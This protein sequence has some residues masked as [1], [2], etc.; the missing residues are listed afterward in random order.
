MDLGELSQLQYLQALA[1]RLETA[2]HGQRGALLASA[3]ADLGVSRQTLYSRLRGVGWRSGRAL[4]ADAGD[5]RVS[6]AEV[7]EL[8]ALLGHRRSNGKRLMI[9]GDA[10]EIA[11]ANGLLSERISPSTALR[12]MRRYNCHPEQIDR[13]TPHQDLRSLHPN[14]VWQVDPSICVLFY[15]PG[16]KSLAVMDER[17]FNARKPV[18]L[19]RVLKERVIRYPVTDH[20]TGSI[21]LRY[22]LAPGENQMSLFEVLHECMSQAED[23]VMHGVPWQLI[24]DAGSANQSH[25][26]QNLW[27]GLATR[28]W[29]HL[30]QNPRGKGQVESTNNLVERRFESRLAFMQIHDLDQL[31]AAADAW[32]RDFNATQIHTRHGY[33]RSALWQTIRPEQLRLCPPRDVCAQLMHSKPEPRKVAGNLTIS[34]KPRGHE[35]GD[36][37]VAHIDDVRVGDQLDVIVNPYKAP[38]I[39]VITRDEHNTERYVECT[40][41]ERDGAG[42]FVTAP[43][44]GERYARPAD[45]PVEKSRADIS[46]KLW[47]STDRDAADKARKENRPAMNGRVDPMADIAARAGELPQH[48]RRRGTQLHLPNKVHVEERPVSVV[49]ALFDLRD[50]LG[51][52]LSAEESGAVRHWFPEGVPP[53]ALPT[54]VA[55]IEQLSQAGQ[56]PAVDHT[57]PPR[58]VAV[59]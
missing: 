9:V 1:A 45:T 38:A 25:G 3:A 15:M 51:R 21:F 18:A 44:I 8:A 26:I 2:G 56:A 39:Y 49:D 19:S 58:L 53:E 20:Y 29:T 37:S 59:R 22:V 7:R 12:L 5:S 30:P 4:R 40:P 52:P 24:W 17:Q 33:T 10:I 50:R 14:H 32:C 23:R 34:F 48:I 42:F 54:L 47:G 27:R 46:Q 28:Q 43:V 41:L 16:R 35:R 6:E 55:R 57:E 31:N 11:L 36:Y 13:P